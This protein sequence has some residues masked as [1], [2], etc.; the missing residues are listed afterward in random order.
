[1]FV[2]LLP[3]IISE[4]F[5]KGRSIACGLSY[6][7]CTLAAFIFPP[8]LQTLIEHFNLRSALLTLSLIAFS[9]LLTAWPLKSKAIKQVD[10][11]EST[12]D[13][14]LVQQLINDL[15]VLKLFPFWIVTIIYIVFIYA[16]VVFIIILPDLAVSRGLDR[17]S[18]AL[19]LSIYSIGD[20]LGRLIPGYLHLKNIVHNQTFYLYSLLVMASLFVLI[21]LYA[22]SFSTFSILCIAIGFVTGIQMTLPAVVMVEFIGWYYI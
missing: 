6:S 20:F 5:D 15:N 2:G 21:E 9:A 4:D 7:G 10:R 17:Q 18:A 11:T 13:R 8:L 19:L 3:I 12:D 22:I 14:S 1:M 16:F